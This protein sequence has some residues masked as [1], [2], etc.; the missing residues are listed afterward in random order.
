MRFRLGELKGGTGAEYS[1]FTEQWLIGS[2]QIH[3]LRMLTRTSAING[4]PPCPPLAI[5]GGGPVGF[6]TS[7]H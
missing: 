5:A 4:G 7:Q 2:A 3:L 1:L 6:R